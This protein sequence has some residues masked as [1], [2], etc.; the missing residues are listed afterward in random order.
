MWLNCRNC[1]NKRARRDTGIENELQSS[2]ENEKVGQA[3]ILAH[4][5]RLM[6]GP[7]SLPISF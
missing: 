6:Q 3:E 1:R 2:Y 5:N 4:G 7:K